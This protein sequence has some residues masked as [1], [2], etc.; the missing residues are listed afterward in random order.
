MLRAALKGLLARK[1]RLALAGL[2]VVLGVLA[3]SAAMVTTTTIGSGFDSVFQTVN[4][5]VDVSVT[6]KSDV[7]TGGRGFAPPVPAAVVDEVAG[8]PG[9]AKAAGEVSADGARPV[10][11]DG[12]VISVQGPPRLGKAW[13]G[14]TGM[15]RLR[16]GR[17]PSAPGE[18]A[19]NAGLAELGGYRVGGTIDV[20]TLQPRKTFTVVGIYGFSNGLGTLGGS[21]EVSFTEPVAQQL[22]L[23]KTGVFSSVTVNA[24]DGVTP[25]RLRDR[26]AGAL[27]AGYLSRTG[28][29]LAD[30]TAADG[31]AFLEIVRIVLL[32]FSGLSLLVGIF[33][34]LNTFSILV[35]QRT[36]ELALMAALGARRRQIVGAVLVEAL[37][38]GSVASLAGIGLGLGVSVLLKSVMEANSGAQLPVGLIVPGGDLVLAF[39]LGVA[40]TLVAALLPAVRASRVPP[41]E[42]MRASAA[43]QRSLARITVLGGVPFVLGVAGVVASV[44]R[45]LGGYRWAVLAGGVVLALAG[46]ALLTPIASR[47]LLPGVGRLLSW[48]MPGKLGR[49]NAERNPRRTAITVATLVVTLG[50]VGGVGV[51]AESLRADVTTRVGTDLAADFVIAGDGV[52]GKAGGQG[53]GPPTA[54]DGRIMPA[55]EPSVLTSAAALPGVAGAT[56]QYVGTVQVSG[57]DGKRVASPANGGALSELTGVLG[58]KRVSGSLA[59][60]RPGQVVIDSATLSSLGLAVGGTVELATP[61]GGRHGYEIAGSYE[62]NFLLSGPVLAPADAQRRFVSALPA[63]GYV[64]LAPGAD[65]AAVKKELTG[66]LAD[67]PEVS[68]QDQTQ[69]AAAASSQVDVAELMLYVLLGLPVVIGVLGIVNTMALSIL[70][71]TREL[72]LLR[73]I[74][75]RR[76]HLVHM[77]VAESVVMAVFGGVLGLAFGGLAGAAVVSV[78]GLAELAVP[79]TSLAVFLG[80]SVVAGLVAALAPSTRAAKVN[81]LSAIAYQ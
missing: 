68:V 35:A 58:L 66:L 32:G 63:L 67:N 10:G 45:D 12:K 28:A 24:A 14:E 31:K 81:V 36:G 44:V 61:R 59:D 2:A 57:V 64:R 76:S 26:V 7:D 1:L 73:A 77:V 41:V 74:G 15:V 55:V 27:G 78:A 11:P 62:P 20:L 80:L 16:Q 60:L 65:A 25:S 42:A 40:V 13:H 19:I 43:E 50:L 47:V 29:E 17:G 37:L 48:S 75:M 22:M 70:E 56:A 30:D 53:G 5:G 69:A 79:W 33:L 21:T 38:V 8:V 39:V 6:A 9:V 34:I 46:L 52:T 18:V 71:R 49:R 72:G 3:V 4:S 23:G 54:A 51:V